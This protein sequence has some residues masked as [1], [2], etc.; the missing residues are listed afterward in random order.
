MGGEG[1][2]SSGHPAGSKFA[3][4]AGIGTFYVVPKFNL[5]S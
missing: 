1:G 3:F 4:G 5:S 2:Y